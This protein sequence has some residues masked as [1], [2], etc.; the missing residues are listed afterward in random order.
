MEIANNNI[1]SETVI[2]PDIS[3]SGEAVIKEIDKYSLVKVIG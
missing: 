1:C 2:S 3:I